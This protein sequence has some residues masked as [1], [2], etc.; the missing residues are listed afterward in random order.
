M[1]AGA[2]VTLAGRQFTLHGDPGDPY[3]A[4][5]QGI[6][7]QHAA[8]E[9]WGRANLP[10]DAV[11][12]DAGANIGLTTLLLAALAP[13]GHLH[14]FEALP[15]NA[16]HLRETLAANGIMNCTVNAVA[17]GNRP[18]TLQMH[19]AGS[20]AHVATDGL[21][22]PAPGDIVVT[23]LD[24]YAAAAGLA[25]LDL[26]KIDVEG[27]EPAVLEG[28]AGVIGT[29][30]P[31]VFMEFNSWC[32]SFFHGVSV[33]D[34]A[35]QLWDAF[36]VCCLDE[37]GQEH[38]AGKGDA[39]AFLHDNIVLHGAVDDVLLRHKPG[40]AVPKMG[41]SAPLL[42]ATQSAAL[43][44]DL[45]AQVDAMRRSTSWRVTAPLRALRQLGR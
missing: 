40:K 31:P 36:K 10:P 2:S 4:N 1:A 16:R 5:A 23:T 25:R 26:I 30:S 3:F 38:L 19:G 9:A 11:I 43:T 42:L 37:A 22:Q 6:A 27:F 33:R 21:G 45:Q 39:A 20:S 14:A 32:L 24:A 18:G 8:L 35:Y 17:L 12:V 13:H 44:R 28:A 7:R 34:F 29:F 15:A 41:A